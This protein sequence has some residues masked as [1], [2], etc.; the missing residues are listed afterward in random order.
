MRQCPGWN[1]HAGFLAPALVGTSGAGLPRPYAA[2]EASSV[3]GR[4]DG[5]AQKGL[6]AGSWLT[7]PVLDFVP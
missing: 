1:S 6:V 7:C 4:H 2:L 5:L 3:A